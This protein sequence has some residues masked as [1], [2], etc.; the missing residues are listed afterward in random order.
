MFSVVNKQNPGREAYY[1]F[2][3]FPSVFYVGSCA[4]KISGEL[5][6]SKSAQ[7]EAPLARRKH[8]NWN[9]SSVVLPLIPWL[10]DITLRYCVIIA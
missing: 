9:T 2:I 10:C 3:S 1:A 5:K 6:T 4:C 7:A 8:G